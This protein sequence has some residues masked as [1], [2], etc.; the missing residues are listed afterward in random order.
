M[1][2]KKRP[3]K[4]R[5]NVLNTEKSYDALDVIVK[6]KYVHVESIDAFSYLP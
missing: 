1:K 5:V 6:E 2:E 4:N 3:L